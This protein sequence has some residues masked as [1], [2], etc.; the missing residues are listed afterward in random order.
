MW[1]VFRQFKTAVALSIFSVVFGLLDVISYTRM[2]ATWD[3]P[4]TVTTGYMMLVH[5]DYRLDPTHPPLAR[6]WAAIPLLFRSDI[7]INLAEIDDVNPTRWAEATQ[8][9]YA[10]WFMY[11]VNKA[12]ALLYASRFMIVL[13]GIFL[14]WLVFSWAQELFGF[15]V[16]CVALAFYTLEP[17][18]LAHSQLVTTDF[19]L[20]FGFFGTLYFLWCTVKR[21]QWGNLIMLGLFFAGAHVTK[22]SAVLLMPVVLALLIGRAVSPES[23]GMFKSVRQKLA[24]AVGIFVGLLLLTWVAIW[25][26]YGFRYLPSDN[27][28]WRYEFS[29]EHAYVGRAPIIAAAVDWVDRHRLL[30]NSYSQGF[31]FCQAVTQVRGAYFHGQYSRTGW[32]YYFPAAILLKTPVAL[33]MMTL[34]GLSFWVSDLRRQ[35][36]LTGTMLLPLAILIGFAMITKVNIGLRHMLALYPIFLMAAAYTVSVLLQK[37]SRGLRTVVVGVVVVIQIVE[38]AFVYPHTLAFF[39]VAAGG[40]S[41]GHRWLVDSNL[42][43][44]QDLKRLKHWMDDKGVKH[45]NL[46]YFGSA[47]PA[48]Y[49]IDNTPILGAPFFATAKLP[50]LPGY[51]AISATNLE[52]PYM[53]PAG[54]AFYKVLR[55]RQPTARVGYSILVYWVEGS[56][57]GGVNSGENSKGTL[58]WP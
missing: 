15:S 41:N 1:N 50:Q 23:W 19:P 7:R 44:G 11:K 26:V 27:P 20:A 32:W 42:D 31:L 25:T 2:S 49:G 13:L 8:F 47:D 45:I 39:N 24:V 51:V 46:S 28:S 22:F 10:H 21:L 5:D 38:L 16:A 29:S 56:W 14:G 3:E 54:R 53:G 17:N 58:G 4:H 18:I 43:W 30:P 52:G 12:D 9:D 57:W 55:E 40:P 34:V 37:S 33:L 6:L 35:W 36:I 48:Y